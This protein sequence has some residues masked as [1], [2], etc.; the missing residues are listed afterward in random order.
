M[1]P[2]TTNPVMVD[3]A[4]TSVAATAPRA[5]S[6]RRFV[7]HYLEM[8][9][10][11]L[12]GMVALGPVWSFAFDR[13]GW[14]ATLDRVEVGT[15]VM[16]T[17]MALAMAAWMRFRKHRW[18]PI[19]E[20]SAAMYVPFVALLIPFWMGAIGEHAIH[21]AGHALMLPAMLAVMLLRRDEYSRPH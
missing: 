19:A 16:A 3:S 4:A 17:D 12:I 2:Q 15:L 18:A 14:S 1:N 8:V 13:L 10:A 6:V 7:R 9:V 5:G 20:M 21:M 11:M